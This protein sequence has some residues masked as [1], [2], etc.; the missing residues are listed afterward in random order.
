MHSTTSA[1]ALLLRAKRRPFSKNP[2]MLVSQKAV[3][4]ILQCVDLVPDL[5]E[6]L[7][8]RVP[9][10]AIDDVQVVELGWDIGH[11]LQSLEDQ[12]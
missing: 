7:G 2:G 11:N 10:G 3:P 1:V 6:A 9:A 8:H 12:I 5:L 4:V